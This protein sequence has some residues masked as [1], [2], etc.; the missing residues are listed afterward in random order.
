MVAIYNIM[1]GIGLDDGSTWGAGFAAS[2]LPLAGWFAAI[3]ECDV[4]VN[5]GAGGTEAQYRGGLEVSVDDRHG[6]I[7]SGRD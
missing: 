1:R 7:P 4:A 2:D 6:R 5:N 3:N